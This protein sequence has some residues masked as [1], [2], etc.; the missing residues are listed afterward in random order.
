MHFT[1]RISNHAQDDDYHYTEASYPSCIITMTVYTVQ[2]TQ[3]FRNVRKQH[4]KHM[5]FH[6][7][8]TDHVTM[9]T[10]LNSSKS[11]HSKIL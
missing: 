2:R 11:T 5:L 9:R 7:V 1:S 3:K 10:P 6:R 4:T 8:L